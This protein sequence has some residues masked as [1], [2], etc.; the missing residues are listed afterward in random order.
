MKNAK[1]IIG[2]YILIF[3]VSVWFSISTKR[4]RITDQEKQIEVTQY[5]NPAVAFYDTAYQYANGINVKQNPTKEKEY[6]LKASEYNYG[7]SE[8][9]LGNFLLFGKGGDIDSIGAIYWFERASKHGILEASFAL[10]CIYLN[11][12]P[13]FHND[14]LGLFW[15]QKA[16]NYGHPVAQYHI[17]S[18][19]KKGVLLPRDL[20]F[21]VLWIKKSAYHG[22]APAEYELGCC[23]KE[24]LCVKQDTIQALYWFKHSSQQG[25]IPAHSQLIIFT[26]TCESRTKK[27][28]IL[29]FPANEKTVKTPTD[30]LYR[31][32][33][34]LLFGITVPQN[35]P[36]G[37]QYLIAA[38]MEGNK[39]AK[40]MLSYC[41]ATAFG[42]LLDKE[43]AQHLYVGKGEIRFDDST[44]SN[45]I[46]FEIKDDGSFKKHINF[47]PEKG[48]FTKGE[49]I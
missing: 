15:F 35:Q 36:E 10:G 27:T 26:Q 5:A 8:M 45:L 12:N 32:G 47:S 34:D 41:F 23:Y 42:V 49:N 20:N 39:N 18:F 19:Y 31:H 14:S 7:P 13:K 4:N 3:V 48:K 40:I 29:T 46:E 37:I 21:Y 24:G 6:L 9:E 11:S 44:G 33:Y 1:L 43:A 38:T 17:G 25:Y 16:A 22:Y 2:F 30:K 28:A